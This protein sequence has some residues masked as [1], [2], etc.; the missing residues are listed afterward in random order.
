MCLIS[1]LSVRGADPQAEITVFSDKATLAR[2]ERSRHQLLQVAD[3]FVDCP[4]EGTPSRTSRSIKTTLLQRLQSDLVYLDVDTVVLQ[5]IAD[6]LEEPYSIQLA[7][8]RT[9]GI[10]EPCFPVWYAPQFERFGWPWPTAHYYNSGVMLVRADQASEKLFEEWHRRWRQ[11]LSSGLC[12]D[13]PALNSS[14][15]VLGT[16]VGLLPASYN[17]MVRVDD[18]L[19][20][21]AKVLHFFS[22]GYHISAGGNA[23]GTQYMQLIAAAASGHR[24]K[25]EQVYEAVQ[26]AE[27]LVAAGEGR[28][29]RAI[30]LR[31]TWMSLCQRIKDAHFPNNGL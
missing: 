21:G 11:F 15:H 8:D 16:P 31:R 10:A 27:P 3:E 6:R 2:L 30:R 14:I 7:P 23:K 18:S 25:E 28:R 12:Y 19:R 29:V 22:E 24:L 17:A 4:M 9:P 20:Q 13:Q 5:P 1:A 26:T